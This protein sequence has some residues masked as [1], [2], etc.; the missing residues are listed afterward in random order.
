MNSSSASPSFKVLR[1]DCE[2]DLGECETV[3]DHYESLDGIVHC[4]V[5]CVC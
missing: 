2:L 1:T 5:V 4:K 3:F